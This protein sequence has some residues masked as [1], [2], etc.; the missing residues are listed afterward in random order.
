[1]PP[2]YNKCNDVSQVK[3]QNVLMHFTFA[4]YP[5]YLCFVICICKALGNT[6]VFEL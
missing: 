5:L 2:A 1:M 4:F 6:N 3:D